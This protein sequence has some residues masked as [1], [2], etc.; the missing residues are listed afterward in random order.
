MSTALES[1]AEHGLDH[2]VLDADALA[3]RFPQFRVEDGDAAV[4]DRHAQGHCMNANW[5]V[6]P[7]LYVT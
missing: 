4:L 6:L 3:K 1:I 2:E 7:G 5:P